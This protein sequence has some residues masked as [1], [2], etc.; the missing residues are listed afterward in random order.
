MAWLLLAGVVSASPTIA[1]SPTAEQ[2]EAKLLRESAGRII[3]PNPLYEGQI[4][5][6]R[7]SAN[8]ETTTQ[9]LG[10]EII[11]RVSRPS[12]TVYLPPPERASG[13][14]VIILPGGGY[15]VLSWDMEGKWIALALQDRGIAGVLVKYRLPSDEI[16]VDKTIG[17]LQDAQQ[18]IRQV[19]E[20]AVSWGIDPRKVGAMGFSAGGHLASALGTSFETAVVPNPDHINLRP[21]FLILVYAITSFADGRVNKQVSESLLGD[22]PS[23]AL[24][25]RFSTELHVTNATPPTLLLSASN[26]TAVEY[27]HALNFYRA[28]REHDVA[29]QLVLFDRGEHGFFELSRDEWRAPMWAW[30]ERNGLV[31][32]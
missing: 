14:A 22:N 32:R 12:Y 8:R 17:P 13:A 26:D 18:A 25:R 1:S 9:W 28:L 4:P 11:G 31:R 27:D 29:A 24:I 16:M 15:S 19:R 23:A 21:D 7:P 6:S 5:N 20:H 30:L 2:R 10:M 3:G